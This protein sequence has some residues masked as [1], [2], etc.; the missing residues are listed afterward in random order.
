M[1]LE[2]IRARLKEKGLKITPQRIAIYDAV[3]QLSN[4]PTAENI[5]DYIRVNHPNISVATVYK[6]LDSLVENA[7]LKRV[8]NDKDIMRY[9]AIVEHHHHLYCSE[10]EMISDFSDS[11][12]DTIISEY[13]KDAGIANFQIESITLQITGK[14]KNKKE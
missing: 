7:L 10:T 3:F 13:F 9:D 8:K 6:V 11:N 5:I 4:H 12:L 14:F 1:T 2:N